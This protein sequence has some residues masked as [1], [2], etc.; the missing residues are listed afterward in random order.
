MKG[1]EKKPLPDTRSE[2]LLSG[3]SHCPDPRV[4]KVWFI[5]LPPAALLHMASGSPSGLWT[6][7]STCYISPVWLQPLS[8]LLHPPTY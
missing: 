5:I 2:V 8:H 3:V 4:V 7:L 6:H 1:A